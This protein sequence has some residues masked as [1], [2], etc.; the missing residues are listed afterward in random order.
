MKKESK[1]KL[2]HSELFLKFALGV[3]LDI[4]TGH[5]LPYLDTFS[6][7]QH[8]LTKKDLE[9]NRDQEKTGSKILE[10]VGTYVVILQLNEVLENEWGP[11]RLESNDIT[12]RNLS[13]IVR[14]IRNAFA[15]D[16][17]SP[18]WDIS[19]SAKNQKFEIPKILTLN[20]NGLHRKRVQRLDYGGPLAI[21]R[22]I[23]F[24]QRILEKLG[25]K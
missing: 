9:L 4:N 8:V 7:G 2:A 24:T 5:T 15:H 18:K 10:H 6:F 13:Q 22:L 1:S 16:P 19:N 25:P 14:L 17:F 21:L 20:T 3:N 23:Q 12:V 11:S